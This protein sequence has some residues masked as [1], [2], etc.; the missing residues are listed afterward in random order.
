[1]KKLTF[2]VIKIKHFLGYLINIIVSLF[3]GFIF[4]SLFRY[5]EVPY[6]NIIGVIPDIFIDMMIISGII[7][8]ALTLILKYDLFPHL[9]KLF[10][11]F[12]MPNNSTYI[13]M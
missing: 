8:M 12:D 10:K 11:V 13:Y 1:M 7:Y 3:V 6:G 9:K 5:N 4:S 2:D